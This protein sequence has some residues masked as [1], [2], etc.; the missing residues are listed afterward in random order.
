MLSDKELRDN[1]R[2]LDHAIAQQALEG[3]TV[4]EATVNDLQ[5]AS[6]GEITTADVIRNI[7]TRLANA[8]IFKP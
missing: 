7:Y 1:R 4:P 2:A 6:L 8:Q 3:L 5:R